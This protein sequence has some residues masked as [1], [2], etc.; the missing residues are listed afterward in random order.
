MREQKKHFQTN[1][2]IFILYGVLFQIMEYLYKPYAVKFLERIGG[3]DLLISLYNS[4]QGFMMFLT[5]FLGALWLNRHKN[6][7]RAIQKTIF[8]SRFLIFTFAFVPFFPTEYRPWVFVFLTGL[9]SVPM[10]VYLSGYQGFIGNVFLQEDRAIAIAK[11]N[12]YGVYAIMAVTFL[13]GLILSKLPQNEGERILI[14]QLFFVFSFIVGIFEMR[15]FGRLTVHTQPH[16]TK[17]PLKK[18][19]KGIFKNTEFLS[20]SVCSLIF[21]FGWQ[22][23]WPLFSIYTIKILGAD[24]M[25]LAIINMG[26]LITMILGHKFWPRF[27]YKWGTP[28][29][30]AICTLGMAMTPLFYALSKTLYVLASVAVITGIFTSGTLTVLLSGLLEVTPSKERTLYM[31]VYNTLIN[32]SLAV[33]PMVGHLISGKKG[34][35]FSLYMVAALRVIG[36]STFVWRSQNLKRKRSKI[37]K[38]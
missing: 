9:M 4:F 32:L 15:V 26:S 29:V 19:L 13:G 3:S 34:I 23:G 31:G 20:F 36:G 28:V 22:M 5:V 12:Q 37:R 25:W 18:T 14:Y 2:K 6:Q 16:R 24:E 17:Q 38:T 27:I 1:L 33:A 11:R 35:V 7:Q 21:H 30:T 10:A 8:A